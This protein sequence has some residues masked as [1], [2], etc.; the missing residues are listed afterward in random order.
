MP[1]REYTKTK[2][3]VSKP[4]KRIVLPIDMEHY[5]DVVKEA[6]LF[7]A[8]ID[9]NIARWPELFPSDIGNGY[10]LHSRYASTKM[11]EIVLR[12]IELKENKAV[13]TIAP[14]GVM[15]Y[16]TSYTDG[17]EKALF[18]LRFGV[19]YWALTY[20]FGK[21]DMFWFRQFCHFGRNNIV[22]TTVKDLE[23]LPKDL[24]GDEKHIYI[25][26]EKAYIATTV[27][28]D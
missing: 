19:P 27:A 1:Q 6:K 28:A 18:L 5:Q 16:M 22:Q 9:Q 13:F 24:L 12:R 17:V 7:R 11:P 25:N 14:S 10:V 21:N 3:Q 2:E 4:S 20:V 23:K 8:W 15:P 26:G